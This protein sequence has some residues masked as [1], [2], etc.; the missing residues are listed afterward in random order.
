MYHNTDKSNDFLIEQN[1]LKINTEDWGK[2]TNAQEYIVRIYGMKPIFLSLNPELFKGSNDITL[3]INS[4]GLDIV[5]DIPSV[6][7]LGAYYGDNDEGM[8]FSEN[9]IPPQL[10]NLVDENGMIYYNDML[11]TNSPV[12]KA[13]IE[14]TQT[15]ACLESIPTTRITLI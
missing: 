13:C 6:S 14:A 1:G 7:D 11:N 5:A 2:T 4:N 15:A 8:W 3:K 9:N 12:A 10:I